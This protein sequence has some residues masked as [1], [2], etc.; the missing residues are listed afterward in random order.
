MEA[1]VDYYHWKHRMK[2]VSLLPGDDGGNPDRSSQYTD[3]SVEKVREQL[4]ENWKQ[5][6]LFARAVADRD[7]VIDELHGSIARRDEAIAERDKTIKTIKLMSKVKVA[8]LYSLVGGAAA[9]GIE[10]FAMA[11]VHHWIH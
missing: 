11:M 4:N 6:R 7:R 2:S 5:L 3:I 8:V 10:V 1:C 9:K